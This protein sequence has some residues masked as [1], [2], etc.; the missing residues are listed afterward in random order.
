MRILIDTNIFIPLEDSSSV[1]DESFSEL[2]RLSNENN[3]QILAHPSSIDDIERDDDK[4]RKEISLSRIRK[5]SFLEDP[6][7]L[8][9][10]ETDSLGLKNDNDR[11]DNE[12]LFAIYKDAA[13]ILVT[14][15]RGIHKKAKILG[16]EG[17]VHYIQQAVQSLKRLHQRV[18]VSLP[19]IKEKYLHQL[20]IDNN[21]FDSLR[22]SYS[23][24]NEWY[25]RSSRG[26][27][28]AW[29]HENESGEL[30]A[31]LIYKQENN[32]IIT[33]DNKA[34]PGT[35]LKL[36]TFKVGEDIRGRKIGELFLKAAFRYATANKIEHIYITIRSGKHEFLEDLCVDFGFYRY[37]DYKGD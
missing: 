26:G 22:E 14:E 7:I 17:R 27:R 32:E 3:H 23:E 19:N 2:V 13:N 30:G 36:C 29:L 6:P 18:H 34:L 9:D 12:I 33:D 20:D 24:F 37:G 21:F 10:Q 16:I 15:D 5:Y 31:I 35:S 11:V 28:K 1:L 8:S 4:E 25:K